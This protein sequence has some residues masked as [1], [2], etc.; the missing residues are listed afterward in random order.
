MRD[1][2]VLCRNGGRRMVLSLITHRGEII[3]QL[4]GRTAPMDGWAQTRTGLSREVN[5]VNT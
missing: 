3:E 1:D 4:G 5:H 2:R